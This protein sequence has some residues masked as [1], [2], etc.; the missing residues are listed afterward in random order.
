METICDMHMHST[1]SDGT[2]TP[3]ELIRIMAEKGVDYASITDHDMVEAYEDIIGKDFGLEKP[4]NLVIGTELAVSF[5]GV[6]RDVLA[7]GID[8]KIIDDFVKERYSEENQKKKQQVLLREYKKMFRRTGIRFDEDV[9]VNSGH[10][11]AAFITLYNNLIQYPENVEKYPFIDDI[12]SFF[13]NYCSD[14]RKE[15]FVNESYDYP[16]MQEGID[17]IHEAGGLAFLAHP[18]MYRIGKL[19]TLQLINHAIECG[20]DGIEVCHSQHKFDDNLFLAE[21]ARKYKLLKS[22][23]SDFHGKNKPDIDMVTGKGDLYIPYN[24]LKDWLPKVKTYV[25]R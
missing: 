18:C 17:L 14:Q 24:M 20:I 23:G 25:V 8:T 16:T 22:G 15:F 2:K 1:R 10:K 13:W 9:T 3:E 19:R 5:N 11:S 4:I 7:Y 12:T 6:I 21:V